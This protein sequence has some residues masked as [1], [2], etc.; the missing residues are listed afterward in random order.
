M[1]FQDAVDAIITALEDGTPQ[2]YEAA[3]SIA[4]EARQT[5]DAARWHIGDI[6]ATIET[7]YGKDHLGTFAKDVSVSKK[8]VYEY[9]HTAA[10]IDRETRAAYEM[11]A[12][13]H[14]RLAARIEQNSARAEYLERAA[15]EAWTADEA[16]REYKLLQG[17]K[18][19]PAI[20]WNANMRV[21]SVN[22]T[23]GVITLQACD[24][25]GD[26]YALQEA[27]R[28]GKRVKVKIIEVIEDDEVTE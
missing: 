8:T 21:L 11:L 17:A 9:A 23:T 10:V 12:W 20:L 28:A 1:T 26:T 6:A 18:P 5:G 7:A 22:A 25:G 14:F 24:A 15:N 19:P 13:T 16:E 27:A 4:Q 2:A 3:I